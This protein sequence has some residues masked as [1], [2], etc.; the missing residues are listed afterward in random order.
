MFNLHYLTGRY[1]L[2]SVKNTLMQSFSW[3]C[4]HCSVQFCGCCL[5]IS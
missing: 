3:M 5:F 2:V 4:S 1:K